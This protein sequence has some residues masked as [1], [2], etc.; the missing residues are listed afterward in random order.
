[1]SFFFI[2]KPFYILHSHV[3]PGICNSTVKYGLSAA[4]LT[5]T[6]EGESITYNATDGYQHHTVITVSLFFLCVS[7]VLRMT[8]RVCR[9]IRVT[10]SPAAARREDLAQSIPS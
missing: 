6:S 7:R 8:R 5:H 4:S 3:V 2:L 10:T 1:M 9:L